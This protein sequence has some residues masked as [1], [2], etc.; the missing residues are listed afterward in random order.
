MIQSLDA[1]L[2]RLRTD[3][4]DLYYAHKDYPELEIG[5]IVEAFDGAV[6]SGKV[7]ALGASN[8]NADRLGAALAHAEANGAA[9]FE[10]LPGDYYGVGRPAP[11]VGGTVFVDHDWS[12]E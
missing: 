4:I 2:E 8:F 11:A 1:S 5:Q 6:R 7:A 3:R 12:H 9:R 10:V